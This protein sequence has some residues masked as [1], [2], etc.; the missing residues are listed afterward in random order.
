MRGVVTEKRFGIM[1]NFLLNF[2]LKEKF[3]RFNLK[4]TAFTYTIGYIVQ[5]MDLL[6]EK[7]AKPL[8]RS[9]PINFKI[10]YDKVRYRV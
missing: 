7:V 8:Y 2:L 3:V 9:M 1:P 4:N 5:V 10:W 6:R